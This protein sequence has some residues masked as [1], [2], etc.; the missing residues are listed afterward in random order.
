M[1]PAQSIV[2]IQPVTSMSIELP[3]MNAISLSAEES[4]SWSGGSSGKPAV[5][6]TQGWNEQ[7]RP[8]RDNARFWFSVWLSAGKPINCEL[9]KIMRRTR[10]IFHYQIKK[11]K[12]AKDQIRKEK[13]LSAVLDPGSDVDLFK[14]IK[15]MR[16]AKATAANKIDDQTE[17]ID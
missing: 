14:E 9:H 12:R 8:F 10:N 16:R 4:L 15:S 5:K 6:K 13:L 11:C 17:G 1:S 2:E 7:V 3:V